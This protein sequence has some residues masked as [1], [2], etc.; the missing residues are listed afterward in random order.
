M[1]CTLAK[2]RTWILIQKTFKLFLTF[3]VARPSAACR[4]LLQISSLL[5]TFLTFTG[6]LA[7]SS[8]YLFGTNYDLIGQKV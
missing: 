7:F 8:M 3:A 2:R 4:N 5:L 6:T 1:Y